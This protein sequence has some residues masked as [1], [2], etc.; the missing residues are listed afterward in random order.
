MHSYLF[1]LTI[2]AYAASLVLYLVHLYGDRRLAGQLA[3][4]SLAIGLVLHYLVLM[5]RSHQIHAV[6]YEDLYGSMSLFGWLLA[7]TYLGLELWHR[8]RSVG[9]FVAPFVLALFLAAHIP[10]GSAP[11]APP[12][13]GPLFAFH[14]TLS[15]LAYAAFAI[16]FVLS[17]I[18]LVQDRFLRGRKLAPVF[19]RF[20]PLELLERMSRS[21]VWIGLGSMVV[22]IVSGY[23]WVHRLTGTIWNPDVKNV[24]TLLVFG[25]YGA[26][27][28]LGRSAAWRG[29]RASALC[30]FNFVFVMLSYTVVNLYLSHYHRYF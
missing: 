24:V 29:A 25:V 6:P 22:G 9:A 10:S 13:H 12:A 19:W 16:S 8:Q 26:Y 2:G 18:F 1:L 30:V 21:S 11:H 28:L 5:E 14:V 17:G 3:S 15:I 23:V 20:P 7:L 4:F 27:I